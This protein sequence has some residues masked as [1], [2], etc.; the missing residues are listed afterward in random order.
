[1]SLHW[2]NPSVPI[3]ADSPGLTYN[4][5]NVEGAAEE[6]M[7]WTNRGPKW[8]QAVQSCIDAF[9]GRVAPEEARKAFLAAAKECAQALSLGVSSVPVP[10]GIPGGA[11][12]VSSTSTN[13]RMALHGSTLRSTSEPT[14][15]GCASG[16]A[17][18][19]VPAE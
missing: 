6:L 1:M 3:R 12:R 5:N 10:P 16:S 17:T 14:A 19:R 4:V 13:S 8:K 2:F 9:E 7:K 15:L 11:Q 18:S